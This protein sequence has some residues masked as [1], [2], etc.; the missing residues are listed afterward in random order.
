MTTDL[1]ASV[2]IGFAPPAPPAG[3]ESTAPGWVS[4]VPIILLFVVMYLV[5]ILPQQRKAKQHGLLLKA[6]KPGD[7]VITS[8]G[9]VGVVVSIRDHHVT[10]RS[11]ETKLEILKS[12]VQEITERKA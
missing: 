10:V 9:I 7:K 1:L 3:T 4:L 6:L 12:A 5:L 2:L 11:D 8:G